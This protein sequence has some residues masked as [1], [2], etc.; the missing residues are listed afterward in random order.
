MGQGC[1]KTF[2]TSSVERAAIS[3][4]PTNKELNHTGATPYLGGPA[5]PTQRSVV[6]RPPSR[7]TNRN[8]MKPIIEV[9]EKEGSPEF[10]SKNRMQKNT[11]EEEQIAESFPKI[12]PAIRVVRKSYFDLPNAYLETYQNYIHVEITFEGM[13]KH[14]LMDGTI[15]L[16]KVTIALMKHFKLSKLIVRDQILLQIWSSDSNQLIPLHSCEQLCERQT[17]YMSIIPLQN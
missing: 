1:I 12:E 14:I 16:S 2:S 3:A 9:V 11:D 13:R 8:A 4:S 7:Q 6:R 5:P 15:S 17:I 10:V